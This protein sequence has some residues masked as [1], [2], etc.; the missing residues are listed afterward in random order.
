V[1]SSY[2]CSTTKNN[3]FDYQSANTFKVAVPDA[4]SRRVSEILSEKEV[5]DTPMV[6]YKH[7]SFM[8]NDFSQ[9]ESLLTSSDCYSRQV[10][11][12]QE[13]F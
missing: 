11:R 1:P 2:D 13:D 7:I 3:N 6:E 9:R 5:P 8:N 12:F 4:L 10:S